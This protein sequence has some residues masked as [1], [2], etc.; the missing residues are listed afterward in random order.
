MGVSDCCYSDGMYFK[1]LIFIFCILCSIFF[2]SEDC[3][4]ACIVRY[5]SK[6]QSVFLHVSA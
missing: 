4:F 6:Y 5:S 3:K 1:N 2:A